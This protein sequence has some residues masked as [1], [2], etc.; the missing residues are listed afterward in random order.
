MK[1]FFLASATVHRPE[2]LLHFIDTAIYLWYLYINIT[3]FRQMSYGNEKKLPFYCGN[4]NAMTKH[5]ASVNLLAK[6][7]YPKTFFW[8]HFA[9]HC[10]R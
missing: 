3:T 2:T 7:S 10:Y 8:N 9:V 4:G 1:R 5:M 6:K